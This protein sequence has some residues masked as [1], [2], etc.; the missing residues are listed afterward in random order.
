[1]IDVRY[2]AQYRLSCQPTECSNDARTHRLSIFLATVLEE[3]WIVGV[4]WTSQASSN[5]LFLT[6]TSSPALKAASSTCTTSLYSLLNTFT[7]LASYSNRVDY[8]E[9]LQMLPVV[10]SSVLP[11]ANSWWRTKNHHQFAIPCSHINA[12]FSKPGSRSFFAFSLCSCA[13]FATFPRCSW[14]TSAK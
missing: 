12:L 2:D 3:Y 14:N 8:G 4:V 7:L 9:N 1:M 5:A 6:S 10:A 11:V 13:H